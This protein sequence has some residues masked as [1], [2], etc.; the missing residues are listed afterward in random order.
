MSNG[1][2]QQ[3]SAGEVATEAREVS[4]IAV[5]DDAINMADGLANL[6]STVQRL[7]A[8]LMGEQPSIKGGELNTADRPSPTGELPSICNMGMNNIHHLHRIQERL[9]QLCYELGE[10]R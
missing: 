10:G 5:R 9:N 7:Q 2:L 1:G 4:L 3:G 6:D 8:H